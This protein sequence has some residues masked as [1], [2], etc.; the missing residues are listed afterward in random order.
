MAFLVPDGRLAV[1]GAY[2]GPAGTARRRV[3]FGDLEQTA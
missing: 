1:T 3:A 2:F